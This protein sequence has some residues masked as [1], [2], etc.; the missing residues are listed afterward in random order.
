MLPIIIVVLTLLCLFNKDLR[1]FIGDN[2]FWVVAIIASFFY[3]LT[4]RGALRFCREKSF[5]GRPRGLYLFKVIKSR[6][7]GGTISPDAAV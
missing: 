1:P 4:A 7:P 3:C 5:G 6:F 2:I